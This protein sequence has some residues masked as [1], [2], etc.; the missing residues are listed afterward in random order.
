[1]LDQQSTGR[2]TDT[3][4]RQTCF[5]GIFYLGFTCNEYHWEE[6]EALNLIAFYSINNFHSYSLFVMVLHQ[7]G[8]LFLIALALGF[9]CSSFSAA[10]ST[11]SSFYANDGIWGGRA[12]L[13]LKLP[14]I[15]HHSVQRCPGLCGL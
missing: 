5:W 13:M 12:F 9:F 7:F 15:L 2:Q 4:A 6:I 1:M 14:S 11:S 8:T 10:S 3:S